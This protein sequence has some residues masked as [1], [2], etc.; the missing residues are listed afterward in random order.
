MPGAVGAAVTPQQTMHFTGPMPQG[1]AGLRRRQGFQHGS[2]AGA[3]RS[4]NKER[5]RLY[6]SQTRGR[7]RDRSESRE[8]NPSMQPAGPQTAMDWTEIADN[9]SRRL[10]QMEQRLQNVTQA[11]AG[12]TT[13]LEA[14]REGCAQLTVKVENNVTSITNLTERV[15][16]LTGSA[17]FEVQGINDKLKLLEGMIQ[18]LMQNN[19]NAGGGPANYDIGSPATDAPD[20]FATQYPST[21]PGARVRFAMPGG[22]PPGVPLGTPQPQPA[23]QPAPQPQSRNLS[24]QEAEEIYQRAYRERMAQQD[25]QRHPPQHEHPQQQWDHREGQAHYPADHGFVQGAPNVCQMFLGG[26]RAFRISRKGLDK[27]PTFNGAMEKFGYWKNKIID[28]LVEGNHRW[29]QVLKVT[30]AA[31]RP[32]TRE[33]LESLHVGFGETAWPI[34]VDL[35]SF[36]AKMFGETMYGRRR[37]LCGGTEEEEGNG[38]RM[39]QQLYEEFEGGS[40]IVQYAA[41]RTL[42]SWPRCTKL[43]DLHQH[44][45]DWV[46][47]LMKHGRDLLGNHEELY[48]RCLEIIPTNLEEE[49]VNN[50]IEITTYR[51]I[52]D[53]CKRRTL[54][55]R[56]M[57]QARIASSQGHRKK[58]HSV[59]PQ[60]EPESSSMQT[61]PSQINEMV[62]AAVKAATAGQ[63]SNSG[64]QSGARTPPRGRSSSPAGGKDRPPP[65]RYPDDECMECGSKAHRRADCPIFKK[66]ME[67]NGGKWPKGHKGK[68]E[69][70]RDAHRKKYGNRSGSRDRRS[71]SPRS[72]TKAVTHEAGGLSDSSESSFEGSNRIAG[73]MTNVF[74]V[75]PKLCDGFTKARKTFR[76]PRDCACHPAEFAETNLFNSLSDEDPPHAL[77]DSSDTEPES[78]TDPMNTWARRIQ[79]RKQAKKLPKTEREYACTTERDLD[80]LMKAEPMLIAALPKTTKALNKLAKKCPS[81]EE[82]GPD[83]YY[84]MM[85]SGSGSNGAKCKNLFPRYKVHGHSKDRP[86]QNCITACGTPLEHRGHCNLNVEI[87]GEDHILPMDDLDVDV[88]ILSVRRIVRRGNLVKF[89][90]GGGYIQNARTGRKLPFIERQG[91]YFIKVKVKDPS[92]A[93]SIDKSVFSRPG[94]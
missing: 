80:L 8:R 91:V 47:H 56:A 6:R 72:H 4:D 16:N 44:L 43:D 77:T 42:N 60:A 38:L 3:A 52:V 11:V 24:P 90:R 89:R 68:F 40:S 53:F 37:G 28:H 48:H 39:W 62:I 84:M 75:K 13:T 29:K 15:S 73:V 10:T 25:G 54:R 55:A 63:K 18:S 20:D 51:E 30:E 78:A 35:E 21:E 17:Q 50:Q 81:D 23:Q 49:I 87:G 32:I 36:L 70:A 19:G 22:P 26:V 58:I 5:G 66:V 2:G 67:G 69:K 12:H 46:A 74:A 64:G 45:D 76:A 7:S 34:A 31:N 33:Y 59:T 27:L 57:A 9:L 65:F 1:G 94:R 41:R 93:D 61:T 14:Y 79:S 92:P 86:Q 82:L 71:Q 83:E 88:P 85:D